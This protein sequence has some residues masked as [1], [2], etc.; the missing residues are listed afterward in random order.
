M[1]KNSYKKLFYFA[2]ISKDYVIP[3][4]FDPR[5]ISTIPVAVAQAAMESGVARR[6]IADLKAYRDKS[7]L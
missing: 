6:P 3:K 7:A 1:I 5:L 2:L 4:P